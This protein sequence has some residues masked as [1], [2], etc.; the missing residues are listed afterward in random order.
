MR[1]LIIGSSHPWRMEFAC[2]LALRRAG[3]ETLLID[4]RR[5]KR[6]VGWR[7]TQ[8]W[9]LRS[10][11]NFRPDFVFLSKCHALEPDTVA[12]IIAG[13]PNAMWYHDALWFRDV[14]RPAI[15]HIVK[16]GQLANT[17]FVTGFENEWAR[18]GLRAK[19]LPSAAAAEIHP[20]PKDPA[21]ASDIAFIGAGYDPDRARLLVEVSRHHDVRVWG[22]AWE[23]W[24]DQLNWTGRSVEGRDFA[25]VCSS[26]KIMLG[27]NPTKG[28]NGNFISD[29]LWMVILAGAFHLGQRSPGIDSMLREGEHAAWYDDAASC[30]EQC[31]YYLAN[32]DKREAVRA[33]GERYVRANHTY[34]QRIEN[35]LYDREYK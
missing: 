19:W 34:D 22:P 5:K 6:L 31:D 11:K 9:A 28:S 35:L 21:F 27:I 13:V 30:I 10:A 17:F 24:K 20:A 1:V 16:I 32:P 3:H 25:A 2:E 29:R 23:D 12:S 18:H 8:W 4:D 26:T 7:L 33:E 14:D 15:A